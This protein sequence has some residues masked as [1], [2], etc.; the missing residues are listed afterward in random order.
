MRYGFI[1]STY[2]MRSILM[3][4]TFKKTSAFFLFIC[5]MNIFVGGPAG[6][7]KFFEVKYASQADYKVFIVEHASQ[8]DCIIHL[9]G[10]ESKAKRGSGFWFRSKTQSQADVKIYIVNYQSQA[11]LKIYLTNTPSK[12]KGC[13]A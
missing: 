7:T 5:S 3:K 10:T 4:I 9:V 8:A 1:N 11:D 6:A 13:L 12:V 2:R